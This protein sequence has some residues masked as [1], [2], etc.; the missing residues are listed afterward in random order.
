M[1]NHNCKL[2]CKVPNCKRTHFETV[3]VNGVSV[4]RAKGRHDGNKH[5]SD[6]TFEEIKMLF[7]S[8]GLAKES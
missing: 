7:E 6:Y 1:S 5:E 8:A 2:F 4:L 3:I